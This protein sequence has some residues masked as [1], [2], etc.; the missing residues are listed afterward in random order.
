MT[1][2]LVFLIYFQIVLRFQYVEDLDND[3]VNFN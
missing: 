3:S 2:L 1:L